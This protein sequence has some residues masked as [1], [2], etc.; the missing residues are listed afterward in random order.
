[1]ANYVWQK[2][3][4]RKQ[5]LEQYFLDPD[6]FGDGTEL[7]HPYIS[8]NKLF[9]VESIDACSE[10]YDCS[11]SYGFSFSWEERPDGLWEIKFC[12]R[13]EY[14]IRAILRALGLAQD[15]VWFAVEENHT[16]VSKFYWQNGVREDVLYLGDAFFRWYYDH[17][18]F[19]DTLGD[20][21]DEAWYYLPIAPGTWRNWES[22]DGFQRYLNVPVINVKLPPFFGEIR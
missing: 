9:G 13:W 19:I 4:C 10:K 5:V 3:I 8:F 18:D 21:D 6:P 2:V 17:L 20:P 1:M 14:P 11:I 12:T 15:T 7:K 16:Y 22:T